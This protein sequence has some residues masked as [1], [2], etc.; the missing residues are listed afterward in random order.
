LGRTTICAHWPTK[1]EGSARSFQIFFGGFGVF[2]WVKRQTC[3]PPLQHL[4]GY[5]LWY[6][7]GNARCSAFGHSFFVRIGS[8]SG[9]NDFERRFFSG[10]LAL[11]ANQLA[12]GFE[13]LKSKYGSVSINIE[14]GE[15]S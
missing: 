14:T 9:L 2:E 3:L 6:F 10:G 11:Y 1:Q 7:K 4:L 5:F 13:E 8:G 12:Q 15:I